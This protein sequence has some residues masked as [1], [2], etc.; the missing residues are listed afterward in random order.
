MLI[1]SLTYKK[2]IEEVERHARTHMDWVKE[3]YERGLFLASGRKVPRNGGVLLAKD[4]RAD[5]EAF[6]ESD[7]FVIHDI[8]DYEITQVAISMTIAGLE[9]LCD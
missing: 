8:G 2:P 5:I 1:L 6:L 3:G 4:K 9:A 7:P